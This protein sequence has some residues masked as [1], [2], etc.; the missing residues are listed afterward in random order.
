MWKRAVTTL[1]AASV[2]LFGEIFVC[3]L[4]TEDREPGPTVIIF[5]FFLLFIAGAVYGFRSL[6]RFGPFW[7][8]LLFQFVILGASA[9]FDR[10]LLDYDTER[11]VQAGLAVLLLIASI[12]V[13]L[14]RPEGESAT[15]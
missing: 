13:Y 1:C 12:A 7:W 4:V 5:S 3:L 8:I 15:R 10:T 2:L 6:K 11:N 14:R 9:A